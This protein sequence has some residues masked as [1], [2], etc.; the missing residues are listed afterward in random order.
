MKVVNITMKP[1]AFMSHLK[2][3]IKDFDENKD[4]IL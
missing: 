3:Q 1:N 4:T 2:T